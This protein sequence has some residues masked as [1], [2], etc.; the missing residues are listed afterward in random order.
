MEDTEVGTDA[1]ANGADDIEGNLTPG[2]DD[3][4]R[5]LAFVTPYFH[6]SNNGP[7]TYL[8]EFCFITSHMIFAVASVLLPA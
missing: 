6:P 3:L 5:F 4:L 2:T 8:L 7:W 1:N